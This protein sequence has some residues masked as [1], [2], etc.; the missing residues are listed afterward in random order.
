MKIRLISG[1][2]VEAREGESILAALKREEIYLQASC[3]G[4]GSCGKCRVRLVSGEAE[5][6]PSGVL[7]EA[8]RN[9]GMALACRTIPRG[10][11]VIEVPETS[12][13]AVGEKIAFARARELTALL[14]ELGA[15]IE[16][17]V[18]TL[19]LTLSPPSI[20]DNSGD[21]DRLLSALG[22]RG[23]D[24][25]TVPHGFAL[26]LA[27]I[28]RDHGWRV[29][30]EYCDE[31]GCAEAVFLTGALDRAR[32]GIAVDIG[33]TTV[34][35]SLVDLRDG[36]LVDVGSTYNSQMRHGDDVI[37]R[38][39]HA[40]E[41]PG[42]R[43]LRE[44]RRAVIGD[45]NDLTAVMLERHGIAAVDVVAASLSGN[46]TMMHLAWGLTPGSIREAPYIPTVNVFPLW[47]AEEAELRI[48]P[49][50]PVHTVPCVASYVGGDIV[51]GVLATGMHRGPEITLFMD[52]GTNGE[53]A[54]GNNEWIMAAACSA[55][56]CFEGSGIR[57]GMRATQGA[58][59]GVTIDPATGTPAIAV[60]GEAPPRGI[61]GSGMI[62]AIASLYMA[63]IIDRKG[64]FVRSPLPPGVREGEEGLEY[65]L[66]EGGSSTVTLTEVD[67]ENVIR[68]KAAMYAG[69]GLLLRE[70]GFEPGMIER[71]FIAGGFGSYL[72]IERAIVLGMLPDL[73]R[74]RYF[75]KGNTSAA[76]AYLTLLSRRMR[77]EARQVASMMTYV[78]LSVSAGYMDEYMSALFLPHTDM[79]RF[80]T[81]R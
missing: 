51:A 24:R 2:E 59:E 32:Y 6:L 29:V 34:V 54:L 42:G 14:G 26:S 77:E 71:V 50:A 61:C 68:A 52:I 67:I 20:T 43:G 49:A 12:K 39:V 66:Y 8:E 40:T 11:V 33:T 48:N 74:E 65:V 44:L 45:I 4:K 21:L 25:L 72:N 37:T 80:P 64:K 28:V 3:G 30:L 7:P 18:K 23:I 1:S 78:E 5:V 22:E 41:T 60:I 15:E 47:R 62:D 46:T 57:H 9:R 35:V 70:V 13:L 73:P 36:A 31:D 27:E 58:I 17:L 63:R 56:P 38:I 53:V 76:G 69:V 16:P 79:G 55:G 10:D 75:Y 81:V 19:E